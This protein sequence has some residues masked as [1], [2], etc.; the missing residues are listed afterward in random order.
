MIRFFLVLVLLA[1]PTVIFAQTEGADFVPLTNLPGIAEVAGEPDLGPFLNNLYRLLIGAAAVI[2]VIQIM[3]AGIMFMTN[4]G[5]VSENEQARHLIQMSVI[6]LVLILSPVIVF[7]IINPEILNLTV[8]T[9]SLKTNIGDVTV[10]EGG[11]EVVDGD[12]DGDGDADDDDVPIMPGEFFSALNASSVEM[13]NLYRTACNDATIA[14]NLR[15]IIKNKRPKGPNAQIGNDGETVYTLF[16][17]SFSQ[18]FTRYT[19]GVKN[20]ESPNSGVFLAETEVAWAPG[21]QYK[22]GLYE[23]GCASDGGN[24]RRDPD[25]FWSGYGN[26][27]AEVEASVFEAHNAS[28]ETHAVN[29]QQVEY[30]CVEAE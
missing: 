8:N 6:G 19:L 13:A 24:L 9:S 28:E 11:G 10:S 3:R 20:P 26:C 4:K 17:E 29:C 22:Y 16:C 2:A 18:N 21:F 12:T 30:S 1:V 5:S 15:E 14:E 23:Q 7:S 25:L 27:S